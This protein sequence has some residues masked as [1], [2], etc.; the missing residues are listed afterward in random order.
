MKRLLCLCLILCLIY[1]LCQGEASLTQKEFFDNR[2]SVSYMVDV[3]HRGLMRYYAQND[4]LY[5]TVKYENRKRN[6]YRKFATGACVPTSLAMVLANLVPMEDLPKIGEATYQN[7]GV[8]FCQ[9]SCGPFHCNGQH[10]QYQLT[11]AQEYYRYLPMVTG[12]YAC[13]NGPSGT[14]FRR[15]VGGTSTSLIKTLCLFYG[16][17]YEDR[18]TLQEA[19]EGIRQGGIVI[20]STGGRATPFANGGHYMVLASYDDEYLYIMDPML[21]ESYGKTDKEELLEIISPG[22]VRAR[23]ED[24]KKLYLTSFTLISS[25]EANVQA[26]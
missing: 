10:E 25:P 15:N 11:T 16:L 9:C 14:V 2:E 19:L 8:R 21:K 22:L 7:R 3:P 4:P 17:T 18:V 12:G 24:L 1:G 13:G 26:S 6:K 5:E 23:R 20:V